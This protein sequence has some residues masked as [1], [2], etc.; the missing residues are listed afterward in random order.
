VAVA[1]LR[2][3]PWSTVGPPPPR[4]DARVH[5]PTAAVRN[6]DSLSRAGSRIG[7]GR[8]SPSGRRELHTDRRTGMKR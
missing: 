7:R 2:T 8:R 5:G 1:T 3:I 6:K 4:R